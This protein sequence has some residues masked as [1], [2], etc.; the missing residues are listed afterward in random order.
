M[1]V[2]AVSLFPHTLISQPDMQ[3]GEKRHLGSPGMSKHRQ[4]D[5][6]RLGPRINSHTAYPLTPMSPTGL[7]QLAGA[8]QW[9]HEANPRAHILA[10]ACGGGDKWEQGGDALHTYARRGDRSRL[11]NTASFC[12]ALVILISVA[13][14]YVAEAVLEVCKQRELVRRGC[15][16]ESREGSLYG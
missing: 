10:A 6:M 15:N 5:G 2:R 14:Q 1:I 7:P 13:V 8:H 9:P 12:F 4:Y 11:R 3:S 16:A